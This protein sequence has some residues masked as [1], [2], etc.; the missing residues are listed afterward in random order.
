MSPQK[1]LI[2]RRNALFR[3]QLC[4]AEPCCQ[5]G[6]CQTLLQSSSLVLDL[7]HEPAEHDNSATADTLQKRRPAEH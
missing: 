3:Q 5:F 2:L 7:H 1:K 4:N 6:Q